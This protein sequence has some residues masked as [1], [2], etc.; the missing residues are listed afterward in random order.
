MFDLGHSLLKSPNINH[1]S[2]GF[3]EKSG[4]LYLRL[5]SRR[6]G[7]LRGDFTSSRCS[8]TPGPGKDKRRYNKRSYR[9]FTTGQVGE[10]SLVLPRNR[11]RKRER[12]HTG[13][14]E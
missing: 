1:I 10:G 6:R 13:L 2:F 8:S 11:R 14:S 4:S 3:N 9:R 7:I 5:H 12:R